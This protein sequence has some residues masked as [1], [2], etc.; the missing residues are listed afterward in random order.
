MKIKTLLENN[1]LTVD[2]SVDYINKNCQPFINQIKQMKSPKFVFRGI[3]GVT[4][5]IIKIPR[6]N[7]QPMHTPKVVQEEIDDYFEMLTGIRFRQRGV[8]CTGSAIFARQYGRPCYVFPKGDFKFLWSP[9]VRDLYSTL[10]QDADIV[11]GEEYSSA[12]KLAKMIDNVKQVLPQYHYMDDEF[13]AAVHSNYEIMIYC[14][15]YLAVPFEHGN[16]IVDGILNS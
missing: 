2:E 11:S 6:L 10:R 14:A 16:Y 5:P 13:E 3:N 15:E 7:R 12:L 4:A 9:K 8:F 1:N